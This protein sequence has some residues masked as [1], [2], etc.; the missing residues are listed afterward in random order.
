MGHAELDA[1]LLDPNRQA[2]PHA[3]AR[4]AD[5]GLCRLAPFA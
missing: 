4:A 1:A 3:E 2:I 5:G